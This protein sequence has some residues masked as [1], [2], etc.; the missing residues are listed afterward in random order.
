M[1]RAVF[2]DEMKARLSELLVEGLS[3][4]EIAERLEISEDSAQRWSKD[5]DVAKLVEHGLRVQA[6]EFLRKID[7]TLMDRLEANPKE[8]S[9]EV[10]IRL[11]Q[12]YAP[13]SGAS[14]PDAANP[15]AAAMELFTRA[16]E[17]PEA[18]QKLGLGAGGSAGE[19]KAAEPPAQEDDPVSPDGDNSDLSPL[20]DF[21]EPPVDPAELDDL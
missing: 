11:R 15:D 14:D 16:M 10:L 8:I 5:E 1:S 19:A 4:R 7:S 18:A 13:K 12:Q 2:D 9:T 17:N 20:G 21:E 6:N 3:K